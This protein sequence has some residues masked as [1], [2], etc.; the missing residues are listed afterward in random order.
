MAACHIRMCPYT[1][2]PG[3][4]KVTSGLIVVRLITDVRVTF[5]VYWSPLFIQDSLGVYIYGELPR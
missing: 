5:G 1:T 4:T 3:P 2:S